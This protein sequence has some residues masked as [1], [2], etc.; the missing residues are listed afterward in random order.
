M[1]FK[2]FDTRSGS[3]RPLLE[4]DTVSLYVCGIT[5]YDTTHLGH[6][7]TY[8]QFDVL[9]RTLRWLG[10]RVEYV[11]NVT[12]IDD[13]ILARARKLGVDWRVLG[14]EQT[15]QYRADM[16]ALN[17]LPPDHYVRA[18]SSIPTILDLIRKLEESGIAYRAGD[19]GVYFRVRAVP[20]YGELSR[21]SR[22]Q[23]VEITGQQDDSDVDDPRKDDPLDFALWKFWSGRPDEP[24]WPSPWGNG[25]P[26]W[27]IECSAMCVE[28][29]G[30]Q[31]TIHGGGHDL[32]FP[33]HESETAQSEAAT[34]VRPFV[35]TWMHTAMVHMDGAKMSKSLG[36]MVF[37]RDLL[38]RYSADA[39]RLYLLR[40][41]YREPLS[42][43]PAEMDS[44]QSHAERLAL[45]ARQPDHEGGAAERFQRA[46]EEDLATPRAIDALDEAS[47]QPLRRLG[48]VLGLTFAD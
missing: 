27:H 5:P 42:W 36:N 19:L 6:A 7:F 47:G 12:D 15:A 16:R 32:L 38:R 2:L 33:H 46:L 22:E 1:T 23:M 41:H 9:V 17:V 26:G 28:Y 48:G 29:L 20:T 35:H 10:R 37:I 8:V 18:T 25:R 45:A 4:T 21:F 34:G 11:Q 3:V 43:E 31:V 30:P 44:A 14:D 39:V 40:Y 24:Y 13:S